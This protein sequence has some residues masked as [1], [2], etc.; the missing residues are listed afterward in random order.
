MEKREENKEKKL[1]G[2]NTIC[3]VFFFFHLLLFF[4]SALNSAAMKSFEYAGCFIINF[5]RSRGSC[6]TLYYVYR[7]ST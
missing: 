1:V 2:D 5:A 6:H 4:Y 7:G 3:T